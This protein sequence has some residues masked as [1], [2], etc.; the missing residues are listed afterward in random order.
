MGHNC[1]FKKGFC[2]VNFIDKEKNEVTLPHT[3]QR[4][5][6]FLGKIKWE[7]NKLVPRKKVALELLYHILGHISTR[8]FMAGDTENVW[9]NIELRIYPYPFWTPCHIS[10]MNKKAISKNPLNPKA[11][12]KLVFIDIIPATEPKRLTS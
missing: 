11:H 4:K 6:A 7:S 2:K 8:S 12:F 10:S 5:H 1:L 3:A 9:K